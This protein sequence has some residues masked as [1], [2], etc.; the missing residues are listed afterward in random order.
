[1]RYSEFNFQLFRAVTLLM[2]VGIIFMLSIDPALI[3]ERPSLQLMIVPMVVVYL[4]VLCIVAWKW[5]VVG[6][7]RSSVKGLHSACRAVLRLSGKDEAEV[8]NYEQ[9]R[10]RVEVM[11]GGVYRVSLLPRKGVGVCLELTR[12]AFESHNVGLRVPIDRSLV[13]RLRH[14]IE[15]YSLNIDTEKLAH[16]IAEVRDGEL[17]KLTKKAEGLDFVHTP[18]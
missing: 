15:A 3:F 18:A 12:Y 11:E 7:A 5:F 6:S 2:V 10:V 9:T 14:L 1:M 13:V 16:R 8:S 17:E 4:A